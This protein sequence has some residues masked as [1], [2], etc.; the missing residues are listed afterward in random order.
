MLFTVHASSTQTDFRLFMTFLGALHCISLFHSSV[1]RMIYDDSQVEECN[2]FQTNVSNWDTRRD[3]SPEKVFFSSISNLSS[4][5]FSRCTF[6]EVIEHDRSQCACER[7]LLCCNAAG[8]PLVKRHEFHLLLS[9][10]AAF[11]LS[12]AIC[13]MRQFFE[14]WIVCV[15]Q[16][17][18]RAAKSLE[19][20]NL[21]QNTRET[22]RQPII[23][24]INLFHHVRFLTKN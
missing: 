23:S 17:A 8:S 6:C 11:S 19:K 5:G 2:D 7:I 13:I 14:I 20:K 3:L 12:A 15:F 24:P 1:T 9:R 22:Q 16:L 10:V 18:L 21:S 4:W